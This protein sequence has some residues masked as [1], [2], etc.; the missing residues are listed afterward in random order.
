MENRRTFLG[1]GIAGLAATVACPQLS[2]ATE[3]QQT[4]KLGTTGL[5]LP[6]VSMGAGDCND[7]NLMKTALDSG[8]KMLATSTYYGDGN[9]ERV[10]GEAI[11]G[12][13]RDSFVIMTSAVPDGINH[14]E[15]LFTEKSRAKPFLKLF[16]GSLKRMNLDYVDIFT[17][18]FA[19]K[20]E[21]VF[22]E[23]LLKAMETVKK[24]GKCRYLALATHAWEEEAIRAA[25]ETGVYDIVM[26][27][28][29]FRKQNGKKIGIAIQEASEAGLGVI[30]MKTMAGVYYDKERTKPIN[31]KAALKWVLNNPHVHTTVPGMTTFS[32]LKQN[33]EVMQNPGLSDEEEKSL[34]L[35]H[36][37]D[38]TGLYC[39]Q[40]GSCVSQCLQK[41]DIPGFMRSYM[42]AYGYRNRFQAKKTLLTAIADGAACESCSICSVSCRMG[43][44]IPTKI[45]DI[46]RLEKIPD[47]FLV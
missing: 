9:N 5:E 2:R 36:M 40:C 15:G 45:E 24:E 32:Q 18:P 29:N 8:L 38:P 41:L 30:A 10:V 39:Q 26:T 12:R 7:A 22:F 34:Q 42:Y 33:I 11:K 1:K 27:A 6:A 21:S 3:Q 35:G 13:D 43:F 25:V 44:D 46:R 37:A 4:R 23:P 28:Y 19:A 17:L 31:T 47:D 20:R 16:E 14:K